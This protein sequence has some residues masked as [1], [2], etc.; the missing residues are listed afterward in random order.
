[1]DK[2]I[3]A[4]LSRKTTSRV[5]RSIKAVRVNWFGE[6]I[7]T[8]NFMGVPLPYVL[9]KEAWILEGGN[10]LFEAYIGQH[11]TDMNNAHLF[12]NVL[13]VPIK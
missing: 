13:S 8:Y 7:E 10:D 11:I 4:G 1:M 6:F 9:E 2:G 3:S 12:T 5:G